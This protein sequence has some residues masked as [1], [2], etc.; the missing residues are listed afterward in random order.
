MDAVNEITHVGVSPKP[1][2]AP[3]DRSEINIGSG[4]KRSSAAPV[5]QFAT[6]SADEALL[7]AILGATVATGGVGRLGFGGERCQETVIAGIGTFEHGYLLS[8]GN[9]R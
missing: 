2:A 6:P 1:V 4:R 8:V 9:E 3:L 7:I 5:V